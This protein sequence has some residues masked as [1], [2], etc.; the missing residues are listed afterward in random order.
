VQPKKTLI[1]C[2][3]FLRFALPTLLV[4]AVT[5]PARSS[6][7][8]TRAPR[9][10]VTRLDQIGDFI[11]TTPLLRELR[12]NF[13]ESEITLVVRNN[14]APLAVACPYVDRV[15]ILKSFPP[16]SSFSHYRRFVPA[17]VRY[18]GYLR[19]FAKNNLA[20]TVDIAIQPR[21][22]VD[23]DWA[24]LITWLS[25]AARTIGY[26]EKT[27]S[28][29]ALHNA[30]H[31]RLLTDVLP[32]GPYVHE[33]DRNLEVIRY[34][35]GTVSGRL[36]EVWWTQEDQEYADGFLTQIRASKDGCLIAF[37]IGASHARRHWPGYG[38]LIR[39][40]SKEL[41]FIPILLAGP[42][43]ER[44]ARD[45]KES[46][47]SAVIAEELPLG[48]VAAVLS[49]CS[50]FVGNDSGPMHLAAAT[51]LPVVEVSCHPEGGDSWHVNSPCR[52]GPLAL[53]SVIIRPGSFAGHCSG[54]CLEDTAHCIA[55]IPPR[56]VAEA[57]LKLL[58]V[59]SRAV[60][61]AA[62][63]AVR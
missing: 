39:L 2:V 7:S 58:G 20:G 22:D 50:M 53:K 38:D 63:E 9:I 33:A 5:R 45:I 51:G 10:L 25:G 37:G 52:T 54:G 19:D 47:P 28:E 13:A 59:D 21:W 34:L 4:A 35:G 31:E 48:A 3:E 27:S 15:L 36:A 60:E 16:R 11:M 43:E 42:G 12:R 1:R 55:T 49:A 29:K 32:P 62:A 30:G 41:N 61:F 23:S 24:N 56:E 8:G 17:L 18:V 46:A 57:V 44:I 40:L 6:A 14:A 26:T